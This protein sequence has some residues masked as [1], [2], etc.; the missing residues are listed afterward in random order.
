M[1]MST[2]S[3]VI[4]AVLA[5]LAVLGLVLVVRRHRRRKALSQKDLNRWFRRH[6]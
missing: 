3:N 2:T 4:E 6:R 5:A 1:E